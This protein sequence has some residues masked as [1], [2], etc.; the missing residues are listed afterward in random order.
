MPKPSGAKIFSE[1]VLVAAKGEQRVFS[2]FFKAFVPSGPTISLIYREHEAV[3]LCLVQGRTMAQAGERLGISGNGV[4][5]LFV[6]ARRRA[7]QGREPL[8]RLTFRDKP[9]NEGWLP[10]DQPPPRNVQV[11]QRGSEGNSLRLE[12]M[13][14]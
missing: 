13:F 5:K 6:S 11:H 10:A 8:T 4:R 1:A 12:P 2:E 14:I 9:A 3:S 7:S